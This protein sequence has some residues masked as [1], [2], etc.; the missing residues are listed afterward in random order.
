MLANAAQHTPPIPCPP[1]TPLTV[2]GRSEIIPLPPAIPPRPGGWY[3]PIKTLLEAGFALCLLLIL[4]PL[5]LVL[6]LLVRLTSR[7][8]SFYSQMRL[9]RDGRL[10]RIYKLRTMIHNCELRSG[11]QWS[12]PGDPRVTFLGRFLRPTHL[13]EFPQLWNVVKGDMS[14]VGPRPE[15]PEFATSLDKLVPGFRARLLVKP[16]VTGLA[17]VQLP[18]DTDVHSV[19]RKLAYD[20]HYIGRMT[21]WLDLRLI[22]C[23]GVHMFGVPFRWLTR[24]CNLPSPERDPRP[25]WVPPEPFAAVTSAEA[26]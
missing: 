4:S 3:P 19:R 21:W 16:G 14:L 26:S 9:G 25:T 24:L 1:T 13:D 15:R 11:V 7:G 22:F 8:P 2:V 18:P 17:Q 6:A 20:L 12:P 10:F 5:I 23:T